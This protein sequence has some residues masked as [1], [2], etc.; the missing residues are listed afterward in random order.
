MGFEF[1][2]FD[3]ML[4]FEKICGLFVVSRS[5]GWVRGPRLNALSVS[6]C[7]FFVG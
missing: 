6:I 7:V 4:W 3:I 1:F 2:G 5:P